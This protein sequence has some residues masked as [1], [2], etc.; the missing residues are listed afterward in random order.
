VATAA[1]PVDHCPAAKALLPIALL[2]TA[3]LPTALLPT[4][5]LPTALLPTARADR[6]I[7][8]RYEQLARLPSCQAISPHGSDRLIACG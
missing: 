4:A 8:E 3:L 6:G 5:L 1:D 7:G 2:P